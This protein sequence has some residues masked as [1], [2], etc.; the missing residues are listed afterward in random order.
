MCDNGKAYFS[1]QS[2]CDAASVVKVL[3]MS[4]STCQKQLN[5][6]NKEWFCRH[7]REMEATNWLPISNE[8][9]NL[10]YP[11]TETN[12]NNTRVLCV[13]KRE[14]YAHSGQIWYKM[15]ICSSITYIQSMFGCSDTTV[16]KAK[17][18]PSLFHSSLNPY[19]PRV[20][21]WDKDKQ[22]KPRSNATFCGVW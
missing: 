21:L 15:S 6:E 12:K 20:L 7:A 1:W 18:F 19:K 9:L 3:Y 17:C 22:W 10:F 11:F 13:L 5:L 4:C 2:I 14:L 8:I 16:A